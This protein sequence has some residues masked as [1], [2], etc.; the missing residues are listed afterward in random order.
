MWELFNDFTEYV[1]YLS[2]LSERIAH[3]H[4]TVDLSLHSASAICIDAHCSIHCC[5]AL[6]FAN[7]SST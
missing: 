6:I 7:F 4:I 1:I 5:I 2:S 3:I